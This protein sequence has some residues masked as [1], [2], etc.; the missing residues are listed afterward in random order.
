MNKTFFTFI[1]TLLVGCYPV[2]HVIVGEARMPIEPSMVKIFADYPDEYEKIALVDA[3]SSF[4]LKDPAVLFTWQSKM[5]KVIERL[6]I[7][8][9][10]LGANGIVMVGTDNK[11]VQNLSTDEKGNISSSSHIQKI[12]KAVAVYI[13]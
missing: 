11:V 5:D 2:S 13:P 10:Q 4:A 12:G 8:A 1:V 9:S 7:E 3:G 6:K